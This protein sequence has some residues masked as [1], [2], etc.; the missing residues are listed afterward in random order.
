MVERQSYKS[1]PKAIGPYVHGI[2]HN[3]TLYISGLTAYGTDA[4]SKTLLTIG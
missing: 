1:L 4:Q 2:K 3:G